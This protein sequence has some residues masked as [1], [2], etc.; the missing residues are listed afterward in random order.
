MNT[1]I[2][3][4]ILITSRYKTSRA[5]YG[6]KLGLPIAREVPEE[7]FCQFKLGNCFLAIY[8]KRFVETL[9]GKKRIGSPASAI[10]SF[11]QTDD[12][13]SLSQQLKVKGVQFIQEPKTQAWGQRTAYF[14]DPDGH[15]WEIQQWIKK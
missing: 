7:E 9:V 11:A 13:D 14:C 10:Y 3:W 5:F 12:V 15:I 2:E 8:G 6:E 4:I 1:N